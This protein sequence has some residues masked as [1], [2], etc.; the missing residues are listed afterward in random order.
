M[1][2]R[3]VAAATPADNRGVKGIRTMRRLSLALFAVALAAL[4]A[5]SPLPNPNPSSP[6]NSLGGVGSPNQL[7]PGGGS[8][9]P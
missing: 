3:I 9:N 2:R 6:A 4:V 5:C 1:A 7:N 8:P